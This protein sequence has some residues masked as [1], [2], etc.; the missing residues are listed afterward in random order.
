MR[1]ARCR[2]LGILV[3]AEHVQAED[4]RRRCDTPRVCPMRFRLKM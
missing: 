3:R 2:D 4:D 1:Y